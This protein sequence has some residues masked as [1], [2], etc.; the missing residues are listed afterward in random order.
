MGIN[1]MLS[2]LSGSQQVGGLAELGYANVPRTFAYPSL[3]A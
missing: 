3:S 2:I 1:P